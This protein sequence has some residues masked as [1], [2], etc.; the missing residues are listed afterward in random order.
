ME[1]EGIGNC[2]RTEISQD[3]GSADQNV[4]WFLK[5]HKTYKFVGIMFLIFFFPK[6]LFRFTFYQ[7][8]D[9]H[10]PPH[11]PENGS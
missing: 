2:V 10:P 6:L 1:H 4:K 3:A 11:P 5:V 7:F 9:F 8:F